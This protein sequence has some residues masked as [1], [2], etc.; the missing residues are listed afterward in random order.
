MYLPD[1]VTD[2]RLVGHRHPRRRSRAVAP[3]CGRS[4]SLPEIGLPVRLALPRSDPPLR[5][6]DD[7]T[8]YS[9]RSSGRA[10]A[11]GSPCVNNVLRFRSALAAILNGLVARI[12]QYDSEGKAK[13]SGL[14][15]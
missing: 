13:L 14:R 2:P 1:V 7:P 10:L 8:P 12:D 9:E 4:V 6:A 15:K 5:M 3:A 11:G